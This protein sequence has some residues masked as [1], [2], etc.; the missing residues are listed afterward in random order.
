MAKETVGALHDHSDGVGLRAGTTQV[1]KWLPGQ[2]LRDKVIHAWH[3]SARADAVFITVSS[4]LDNCSRILNDLD[5]LP[6]MGVAL[7]AALHEFS[8][9]NASYLCFVQADESSRARAG[10]P[11]KHLSSSGV[12]RAQSRG[13]RVY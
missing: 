5:A 2:L 3:P 11:V 7:P 12:E 13:D 8:P 4:R 9:R 1:S 6:E 10:A